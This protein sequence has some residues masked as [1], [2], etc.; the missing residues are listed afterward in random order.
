[1]RKSTKLIEEKNIDNVS[2]EDLLRILCNSYT[3]PESNKTIF[4]FIY[5]KLALDETAYDEKSQRDIYT[6][7]TELANAG[8]VIDY[9]E[10]N[11]KDLWK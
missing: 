10:D 2:D 5:D 4:N 7:R 6:I 8:I 3:T 11:Y 9:Y 1:M